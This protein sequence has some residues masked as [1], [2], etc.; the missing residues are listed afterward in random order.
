[1]PGHL[2]DLCDIWAQVAGV[3]LMSTM[4]AATCII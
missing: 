4:A 1:M 3:A 2:E